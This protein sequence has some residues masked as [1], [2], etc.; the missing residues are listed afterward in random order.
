MTS[1]DISEDGR[2]LAVT[3]QGDDSVT[4]FDFALKKAVATIKTSSPRSVL[5]RN[6]SLI[7]ANQ[8]EGK[9]SVFEQARDWK[10]TSEVLLPKPGIKHLSAPRGRAFRQELIA[11]C[12]G[13]GVS[14][15]YQD[16]VIFVLNVRSKAFKPISKSA[17]ASVS[18]DGKLLLTQE[19]FNLS[20]SG[21]ISAFQYSEYVRNN[22][23]ARKLFGGGV[24]QTPYVYQVAPG[25]YW[26]S[27]NMV[28]GGAPL[29][30][31][32]GELNDLILADTNQKIVYALNKDTINAHQLGGSVDHV[33]ARRVTFPE[34]YRQPKNLFNPWG[35]R[36]YLLD[37]P[38]AVTHGD[39]LYLVFRPAAG[40]VLLFAETSA[41]EAA[42]EPLEAAI[43]KDK[44]KAPAG[45]PAPKRI[46]AGGVLPVPS[47][48]ERQERK[49]EIEKLFDV[50]GAT[51]KREKLELAN[52]LLQTGIETSDDPV[53]MFVL[54]NLARAKAEEAG[55]IEM[56]WKSIDAMASV[57]QFDA[58]AIR[59]I[60]IRQTARAK[61]LTKTERKAIVDR[62]ESWIDEQLATDRYASAI[63]IMGLMERI[64]TGFRDTRLVDRMSERKQ[65]TQSLATEHANYLQAVKTLQSEPDNPDQL[66]TSG[67]FLVFRKQRWRQGFESLAKG[68][69]KAL[70]EI[71]TMELASSSDAKER[72]QL[73]ESWL[74][75]LRDNPDPAVARIGLGRA[76]SLLKLA[77]PGLTGLSKV[78]ATRELASIE[79][80]KVAL[81][82]IDLEAEPIE[83][84]PDAPKVP[85]P[86]QVTE[87]STSQR[88]PVLNGEVRDA[89]WS[90]AQT[91][92]LLEMVQTPRDQVNG[93]WS[94]SGG[95]LVSPTGKYRSLRLPIVPPDEYDLEVDVEPAGNER[96]LH[97][98]ATAPG[99]HRFV[100]NFNAY[101]DRQWNGIDYVDGKNATENETAFRGDAIRTGMVNRIVLSVR[102][103]GIRVRVNDRSIIHYR[104]AFSR[105]TSQAEFEDPDRS[106]LLLGAMDTV[107]KYHRVTLKTLTASRS[108][109][110]RPKETRPNT[111]IWHDSRAVLSGVEVSSPT[112]HL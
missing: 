24:S 109:E 53:G 68:G 17:L 91:Y 86:K 45:V 66:T 1:L 74:N 27:R 85:A 73:A 77:M 9:I 70:A 56:A 4:V 93:V 105:L 82:E 38:V 21:G 19:S 97:L 23:N 52:K 69:D 64:G 111:T 62:G 87:P 58:F 102:R 16:S 65:Q 90:P 37:Q 12:H 54:I 112:V 50:S 35:H 89:R 110:P 10:K 88:M 3:H 34:G 40:G 55:N 101:T 14:A 28:F 47:A 33:S 48:E 92:D 61:S 49:T 63:E 41:F 11:T 51:T 18:Y 59:G 39:R 84:A 6:G 96:D 83:P 57:F 8:L 2:Y 5:W 43:A 107:A 67:R 42:G 100:V 15:S 31:I 7:V 30:P 29:K 60:S 75:F 76:A 99:G 36:S 108:I 22:S 106:T 103:D 95:V 44:G 80:K 94:M 78:K 32:G 104:G 72:F 46:A 71:A 98:L 79:A 81:L 20:P 13:D 25:G 26:F